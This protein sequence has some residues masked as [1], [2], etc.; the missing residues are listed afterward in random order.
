[1][2]VVKNGK[3]SGPISVGSRNRERVR[4]WFI[5]NPNTTVSDCMRALNMTWITVK[6]HVV[7]IQKG[8]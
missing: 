8:E 1:M 6:K 7:A 2:I 5:K 3:L 4:E